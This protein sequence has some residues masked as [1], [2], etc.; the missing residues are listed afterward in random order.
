MNKVGRFSKKLYFASQL[1]AKATYKF[2]GR[3]IHCSSNKLDIHLHL[4][5]WGEK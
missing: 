1:R 2:L 3:A 5:Y 4:F